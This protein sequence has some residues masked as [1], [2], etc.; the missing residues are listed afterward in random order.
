MK[1]I[2][3]GLVGIVVLSLLACSPTPVEPAEVRV[4]CDYESFMLQNHIN[5]EVEIAAGG[6]LTATLY[7]N[8][9]TGFQWTAQAHI[10]DPGVLKQISHEFIPPDEAIPKAGG[11][12][13]WTFKAIKKGTSI[14]SMEYGFPP[15]AG[16]G[17]GVDRLIM[18]LTDNK[19]IRDTIPF[20][21]MKPEE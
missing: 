19:Y 1:I 13:V 14:V 9:T 11:R 3:A 16:L 18:I 17:M 2:V 21:F 8:P 5:H 20:P 6:E 7:S 15:C 12:E 4:A 10:S